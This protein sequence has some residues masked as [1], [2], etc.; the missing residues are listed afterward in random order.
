M[1][2]MNLF[3]KDILTSNKRLAAYII[4]EDYTYRREWADLEDRFKY[5]GNA[6]VL[7]REIQS[8]YFKMFDNIYTQYFEKG[9]SIFNLE[10][11][12]CEEI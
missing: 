9:I 10:S 7:I 6:E 2:Q 4:L 12:A 5:S 3:V 8:K 11:V 1:A